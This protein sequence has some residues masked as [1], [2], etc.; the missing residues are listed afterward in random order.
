MEGGG[1]LGAVAVHVWGAFV[2]A[3]RARVDVSIEL[4]SCPAPLRI[5]LGASG[6]GK[7]SIWVDGAAA[8]AEAMQISALVVTEV[9]GREE[10][11][12]QD[13][14]SVLL[15][16]SSAESCVSRSQAP[17]ASAPQSPP[18]GMCNVMVGVAADSFRALFHLGSLSWPMPAPVPPH[19][20]TSLALAWNSLSLSDADAGGLVRG[21]AEDVG[22]CILAC[23]LHTRC[24]AV[25]FVAAVGAETADDKDGVRC[26]LLLQASDVA[27]PA[28]RSCAV[29]VVWCACLSSCVRAILARAVCVCVC[30]CVSAVCVCVCLCARG[31]VCVCVC[32]CACACA[33]TCACACA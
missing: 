31:R 22:Q 32:V 12:E 16:G 2:P 25:L 4:E 9:D 3:G 7:V 33:W 1:G 24:L 29:C 5:G 6:N 13:R 28:V 11:E 18:Q 8:G 30:V 20:H 15:S 14:I 19:P 23:Q 27:V 17:R 10:E 21:G 26:R